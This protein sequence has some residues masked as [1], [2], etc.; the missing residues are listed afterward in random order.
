MIQLFELAKVHGVRIMGVTETV[1]AVVRVAYLE[2]PHTADIGYG[3][4]EYPGQLTGREL[5][6]LGHVLV[7]LG[8]AMLNRDLRRDADKERE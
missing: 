3:D 6:A 1:N 4:P 2:V 5:T 7:E 8:Q